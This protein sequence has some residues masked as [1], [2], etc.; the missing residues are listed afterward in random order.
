MHPSNVL[1]AQT[2]RDELL[3]HWGSASG[4][5][6]RIV[7]NRDAANDVLQ[8]AVCR[9]LRYEAR[10]DARRAL[11]PWFL[12]IVRNVARDEVRRKSRTC[13]LPELSFDDAELERVVEREETAAAVRELARLRPAHRRALELKCRGYQYREIARELAIPLGTAQTFVHRARRAL[14]ERMCDQPE[15]ARAGSR[16][17]SAAA[18]SAHSAIVRSKRMPASSAM[19]A[20]RSA[21]SASAGIFAAVRR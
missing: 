5:A 8:E 11:R 16:S 14:R 7:L 4:L 1:S 9:A 21:G 20:Q 19:R 13:A 6:Y 3:D 17:I 15:L 18:Q 12:A 2:F 10:F